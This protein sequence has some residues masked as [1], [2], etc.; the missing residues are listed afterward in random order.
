MPEYLAPGV[1]VEEVSFRSKS[2]E[3]VGT[4]TC[5]FAGPTRKGPVGVAPELLTS[6]AD[7]ERTY[8]GLEDLA[9][10]GDTDPAHNRHYLAHA[11]QAFFNNGGARLYVVRATGSGAQ[12]ASGVGTPV[13]AGAAAGAEKAW[14]EAR[15]DG[16]HFNGATVTVQ[17][18][19]TPTGAQA[20]AGLPDGS[21]VRVHQKSDGSS[22]GV[23]L[24]ASGAWTQ[25]SPPAS[26]E[27][28]DLVAD[29]DATYS[30]V[31]LSFNVSVN[32]G[33]NDST[34]YAGLTLASSSPSWIG[35][36]LAAEPATRAARLV[37]PVGLYLGTT[38]PTVTELLTAF[39]GGELDSD[40]AEPKTVYTLSGGSDGAAPDADEY[41]EALG[42]LVG[43]EDVSIVAA[44]GYSAFYTDADPDTYQ[45]IQDAL[46][47]HVADPRRYRMA[48]LDAPP[49]VTPGQMR[50]LRGLVD[51][52]RA[53]L[54]YPW[55]VASNPLAGPNSNQPAEIA[56]PPSGHVCGIYARNDI[57][58]GVHKAPANEVVRGALRFEPAVNFGQQELLN[59]IGV[60]CLRHLE[61]RG[62]RVWGART[63][64][65]DPEWKY[66]N[67]RR[68]FNYIGASIDR[69][70]QWAVFE[71]N[72]E[73]L[74]ANV[75]G[76]IADFL[77][78][79]WRNGALLGSKP[80]EAFFVRCDRSTMTQ[81]DLD[82]G[83]LICL[84]G[85]AV[86]KPAEF[87]I[88]RIGQKTADA[89]S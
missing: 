42:I 78:N 77:Y 52:N 71:P 85:V 67:V 36:V 55:I 66:L 26:P 17:Q 31:L 65:S 63:I 13:V 14:F 7:F 70:T 82:N 34:G 20:L 49:A 25:D 22:V 46:L 16:S 35:S 15:F 64:S 88:F 76:T 79:E 2:I 81:N 83:R 4:S 19:S 54:Y 80:E 62:L 57:E 86:V 61:G 39:G 9:F 29:L 45:A 6:F 43:L 51:S 28:A 58:R 10:T 48:V 69:G 1:Y 73:M 37:Q 84:V 87:V 50:E 68:Y 24:K 5:A 75:R 40:G 8:G 32:A 47:T 30:V 3:G 18:V 72:G 59:P 21:V 33:P 60:N 53:A 74:W 27:I 38:A 23:F 89:K 56:L 44:P 11:A 12:A 41:A